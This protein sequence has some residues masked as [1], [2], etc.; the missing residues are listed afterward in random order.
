[1]SVILDIDE[2]YQFNSA[3][4]TICGIIREKKQ[5]IY[6]EFKN[7]DEV[8]H[9]ANYQKF[10]LVFDSTVDEIDQFLRFAEMYSDYLLRK[11]EMAERYLEGSY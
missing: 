1:M 8:W 5:H 7:L 6:G 3:M 10:G 4:G 2:I 9:D 11:A